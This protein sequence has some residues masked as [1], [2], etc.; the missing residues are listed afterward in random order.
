MGTEN[1][2][3]PGHLVGWGTTVDWQG[4]HGV[5]RRVLG[6]GEEGKFWK[7]GSGV[8]EGAVWV[9]T[10]GARDPTLRLHYKGVG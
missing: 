2:G 10:R 9:R 6:I 7:V 1:Q 5:G 8:R 3:E 4:P